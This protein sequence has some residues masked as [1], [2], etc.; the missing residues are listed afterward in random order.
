[1]P[2]EILIQE[3]KKQL[4]ETFTIKDLGVASYFLGIELLKTEKG[5][6]VNQRKHVMD[7]LAD[8]GLTKV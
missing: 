8:D 1:M 2:N 6:H 3:V 5:L 7:I 4:H